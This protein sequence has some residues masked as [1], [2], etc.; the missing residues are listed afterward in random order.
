MLNTPITIG[1]LTVD[2]RVFL[3]PLAGVSDA[4]FRRICRRMG[5]GLVYVEMLSAAA[6]IHKSKRTIHLMDRDP[7]ED[8][9]G[10]QVT[11][12]SAEEIAAA[13]VML[14]ASEFDTIDINMGCPVK[15]IV[16]KGWGSAMLLD[17]DRVSRTVMLARS[18][19]EKPLS[20]KIRLGYTRELL[21]VD[22]IASRVMDAG[23]DML[24]VHGR[25]RD[26]NYATPSDWPAIHKTA[27]RVRERSGGRGVTVGNGD[28]LN[29]AS[30]RGM[31]RATECD[32]VMVARAALG[33][34]W[35]LRDMLNG[36]EPAISPSEWLETV[37]CHMDLHDSHYGG[38]ARA[39]ILFR[40]QLLWYIQGF[41]NSRLL[42]T[43]LSVADDL[44]VVHRQLIAYVA[45]LPQDIQR[46]NAHPDSSTREERPMAETVVEHRQN[47][48]GTTSMTVA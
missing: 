26:E 30:A 11:G 1:S 7:N 15:K 9:L 19:T 36:T 39:A 5:A 8:V 44:R 46:A 16:S 48:T 24:T 14:D 32:A 37:L 43:R 27:V 38:G 4:P 21:N 13:I 35:V 34:P 6:I 22:E 40:K 45:S 17:P 23:A 31:V 29:P 41:P 3:A 10:V 25:T 33:N 47:A 2:N 20:V 12:S 28:A 18:A 42:R